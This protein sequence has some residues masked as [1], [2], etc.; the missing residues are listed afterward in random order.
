[1]IYALEAHW[2]IGS[3][4]TIRDAPETPLQNEPNRRRMDFGETISIP[5]HFHRLAF[6]S[7]ASGRRPPDLASCLPAGVVLRCQEGGAV[8]PVV[9]VHAVL[10]KQTQFRT[11][12]KSPGVVSKSLDCSQI[13]HVPTLACSVA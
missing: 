5:Y 13:R 8:S 3:L 9:A 2:Q 7:L 4:G 11:T 6:P 1:M 12:K 10:K